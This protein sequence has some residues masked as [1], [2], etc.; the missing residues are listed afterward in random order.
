[1]SA[2]QKLREAIARQVERETLARRM[3]IEHSNALA[4]QA[5]KDAFEKITDPLENTGFVTVSIDAPFV[6]L[7]T[8]FDHPDVS[9]ILDACKLNGL[10]AELRPSSG[11]FG[12]TFSV[13]GRFLS[14]AHPDSTYKKNP[15]R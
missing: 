14:I 2:E 1:M 13:S 10:R 11:H 15:L 8:V 4:I 7:E 6:Q 9:E 3:Q 12:C 5:M